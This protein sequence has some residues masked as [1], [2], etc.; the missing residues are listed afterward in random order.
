LRDY[1]N[2]EGGGCKRAREGEGRTVREMKVHHRATGC[3]EEAQRVFL[4][5]KNIWLD[6]D[7][8]I[9]NILFYAFI[10]PPYYF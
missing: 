1:E 8:H 6:H 7:N 3:T 10:L 2:E 9:F 4:K 5:F